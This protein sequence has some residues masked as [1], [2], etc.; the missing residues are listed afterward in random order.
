MWPRDQL[1]APGL[2]GLEFPQKSVERQARSRGA[3]AEAPSRSPLEW[4]AVLGRPL[5]QEDKPTEGYGRLGGSRPLP[6]PSGSQGNSYSGPLA[7]VTSEDLLPLERQPRTLLEIQA[8]PHGQATG[9]PLHTL[10]CNPPRPLYR[11][12]VV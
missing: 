9:V 7:S 10:R 1:E 12:C 3:G 2:A 5:K 6:Q 4:R 11:L 8:K